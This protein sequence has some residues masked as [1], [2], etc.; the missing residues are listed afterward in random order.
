MRLLTIC[1]C[2]VCAAVLCADQ[3]PTHTIKSHLVN[4]DADTLY[5]SDTLN[6]GTEVTRK[7]RKP[8]PIKYVQST[9]LVATNDLPMQVQY[10]YE[11]KFDD[12]SVRTNYH[13]RVKTAAERVNIKLPPMPEIAPREPDGKADALTLAQQRAR[14]KKQKEKNKTEPKQQK[15][16]QVDRVVKR[17]IKGDKIIY[18]FESGAVSE[19][20]LHRVFSARVKSAPIKKQFPGAGASG[21]AAGKSTTKQQH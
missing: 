14:I 2:V 3:K 18:T 15:M 12:G 11:D 7:V 8:K 21:A 13:Y 6:D 4:E 16:K 9:T 20:K 1:L 17:E 5:Y 19:T 10:V